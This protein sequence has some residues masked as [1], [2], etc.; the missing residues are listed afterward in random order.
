MKLPRIKIKIKII[1]RVIGYY[2]FSA[3]FALGVLG[4]LIFLKYG[5][6]ESGIVILVL[7]IMLVALYFYTRN[8]QAPAT[9]KRIFYISKGTYYVSAWL[10]FEE[11]ISIAFY[12]IGIQYSN[13]IVEYAII[14]LIAVIITVF[15][16]LRLDS[17]VIAKYKKSERRLKGDVNT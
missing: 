8:H 7:I 2:V 4:A 10:F 12:Q 9:I 16:D 14:F 17:F 15:L 11:L 1:K 6:L 5:I 3:I 13:K